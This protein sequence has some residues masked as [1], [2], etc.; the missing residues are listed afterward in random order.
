[1]G[2]TSF[3][4]GLVVGGA[5]GTYDF[6][7]IIDRYWVDM[8][9]LETCSI[10]AGGG[11]IAWI[12]GAVGN[13]L[14]IGPRGAGSMPGPACYGLGGREPTV[15][16]ADLVLG[17]LSPDHYFGG[18]IKLD[19][20][21][22][23]TAIRECIAEPFGIDVLEAARRIKRIVDANMADVIARETF[24]RGHD[25]RE[26]VLF[27]FGGAG[28]THG[29]GYGA[30]L[31]V[32]AIVVLPFSPVFCAWGSST[33]PVAHIYEA[34]RRLE[35][36]APGTLRP[37]TDFAAFNAV[38]AALEQDAKRDLAAAGLD[39][40]EARFSLELDMKYGGQI[41]IHRAPS[42]RLRLCTEADVRAVLASFEDSYKEF[43][44]PLNV[45]PAGGVEAHN[46]VLRVELPRPRWNLPRYP[47]AGPDAS[48][49]RTGEREVHW[50]QGSVPTPVYAAAELAAGNVL[51]GPAIVEAEYTTTAVEPGFRLRV[52]EYRNFIISPTEVAS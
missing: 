2:G 43:F 52:D 21:L 16:D 23:V 1:M 18:G 7:P 48:S 49:A 26:F 12:N 32:R 20:K 33:M 25:P 36:L 44:S 46:F 15:T 6:R 37:T 41:H 38:V 42:P 51:E 14:E 35:L 31:G 50:L 10:G 28:P 27:A 45:F 19:H 3:D 11:S 22:A 5:T 8:S 4:V 17:I 40:D 24:L 47:L 30:R 34:S 13:R 29:V 9:M 39:V